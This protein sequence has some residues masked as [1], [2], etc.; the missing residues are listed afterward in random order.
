VASS[1][2]DVPCEQPFAY[3]FKKEGV[4]WPIG[5]ES[6][7]YKNKDLEKAVKPT[8]SFWLFPLDMLNVRFDERNRMQD[9]SKY[10]PERALLSLS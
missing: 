1:S 5:A 7:K 3:H 9:L 2:E 6:E 4:K 10:W 8:F